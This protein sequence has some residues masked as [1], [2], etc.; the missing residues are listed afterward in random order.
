M[1]VE[2]A[3]Q[4]VNSYQ[5]RW[6]VSMDNDWR[7]LNSTLSY[8]EAMV[9]MAKILQDEHGAIEPPKD[10]SPSGQ[11]EKMV[12]NHVQPAQQNPVK[13]EVPT[14][15]L[16]EAPWNRPLAYWS[17]SALFHFTVHS[18]YTELVIRVYDIGSNMAG[19]LIFYFQMGGVFANPLVVFFVLL[20]SFIGSFIT[21]FSDA[22]SV[23]AKQMYME[24]EVALK[25]QALT[26]DNM[27]DYYWE[28]VAGY[29]KFAHKVSNLLWYIDI[30]LSAVMYAM[31]FGF[32]NPIG[33]VVGLSIS[34]IVEMFQMR[35]HL[36]KLKELHD[37]SRR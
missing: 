33:W 34:V 21:S 29:A 4:I 26:G 3:Q 14:Y 10:L 37:K 16:P 8:D 17:P 13:D 23:I 2:K 1:N 15:D 31:P 35:S 5:D 27:V 18:T 24:Y 30:L 36:K 9:E 6:T 20:L 32:F 12:N 7:R 19:T 25:A 22:I 28:K 11:F